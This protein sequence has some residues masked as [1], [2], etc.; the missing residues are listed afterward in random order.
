MNHKANAKIASGGERALIERARHGDRDAFATLYNEH[1]PVVYR[2][3][4]FRTRDTQLAEDLTQDVF[5]RALNKIHLFV[6][7]SGCFEAWLV[8]IARNIHLDHSKLL[9]NRL[10]QP[11]AEIHTDDEARSAELD[12]LRGLEVVEATVTLQRA[13]ETLNANQ[14]ACI[15]L[16]YMSEL[17]LAE[18]AA[19][20]G[21]TVGAVKTMTFRA[22]E[23]LRTELRAEAVAA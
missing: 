20:M 8:T 12:V 13:M 18:T 17:S 21:R 3:L 23:K 4:Y 14:R 15:S 19:E 6:D 5:L 10:E 22:M 11:F 2:Y 16:R 7:P 1:R 9:R